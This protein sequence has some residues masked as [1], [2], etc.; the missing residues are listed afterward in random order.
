M[1]YIGG[2]F[3]EVTFNHPTLGSGTFYPKSGEAGTIDLGGFR[4]D[5]EQEGVAGNGQMI[6]TMKR[7]RWMFEVVCAWDMNDDQ[8]TS[9]L[10]ALAESPVPADWTM[11]NIS[12]AVFGAKGK[13]VGD[14]SGDG[15]ASTFTLKISGG[16]KMRKI[17]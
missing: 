8:S 9:K 11:T 3:I 13:P 10:G 2:D 14:I 12:G 7:K 16:G 17:V 15:G 1:A 5:D 4:S 6:D